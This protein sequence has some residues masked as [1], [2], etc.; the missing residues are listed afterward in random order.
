MEFD[1]RTATLDDAPGMLAIYSPYVLNTPVSFEEVPPS[2]EEMA[3]RM[4]SGFP[5]LA[6]DRD[7]ELLGYAYGSRHR[8]RAAYRWS[9]DVTVYVSP[10]ARRM[11]VARALYSKLLD[12]LRE[13]GFYN[14]FA[15][16]ALPNE[17]S[18]GFHE[19]MGFHLVGIYRNVGFKCGQW[20]DVGWWQKELM[21]PSDNPPEPAKIWGH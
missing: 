9:V 11:G 17:A 14:A 6:A 19:S 18:V 21:P 1:I 5:W 13:Q 3:A 2:M 15:G 7:G 10:N 4:S 8:D 12:Q 16:I 20:H